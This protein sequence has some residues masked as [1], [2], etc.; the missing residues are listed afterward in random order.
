MD[1]EANLNRSEEAIIRAADLAQAQR[2]QRFEWALWVS[3][4][5]Y[6]MGVA[7]KVAGEPTSSNFAFGLMAVSFIFLLIAQY[8]FRYRALALIAK[9]RD[10][11]SSLSASSAS[12]R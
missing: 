5:A 3:A 10:G 6:S 9:L 1:S 7:A 4:V 2:N 11:S 8:R 12:L